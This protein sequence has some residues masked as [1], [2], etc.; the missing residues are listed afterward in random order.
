MRSREPTDNPLEEEITQEQIIQKIRGEIELGGLP[1]LTFDP[2]RD[3]V[4]ERRER[5]IMN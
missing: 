4:T 1:T 2:L 5:K 3:P